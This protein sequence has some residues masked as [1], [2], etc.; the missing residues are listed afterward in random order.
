MQSTGLLSKITRMLRY[1]AI[2]RRQTEKSFLQ[3]WLEAF[4]LAIGTHRLGLAEYY[5]F[6]IFNDQYFPVPGKHKCVGW[7]ASAYIDNTLNHNYWR[8]CANDK[9]LNYAMLAHYGFPIP[10]AVATY[11]PSQRA[12]GAEPVLKSAPE[13][14]AFFR[15]PLP[16]PVFVKPIHGSYGSG[17][18]LLT[19]FDAQ[20][21][22]FADAQGKSLTLPELIK[23]CQMPQFNG[24]L[25]QRCLQPHSAVQ[26]LVGPNTSCVR[27]IVA[28][29]GQGPMVKAAFWKIAR[30]HNITDNFCMGETGNLLAAVNKETGVVQ[31]VVTGL[32]PD[33][34]EVTHHTDT[35]QPLVGFALPDWHRAIEMVLSASHH[36][37]GLRLQHW[38]VAFCQSGPVLMELNTEADLGVP[39]F[40]SRTPFVDDRLGA[41]L[42]P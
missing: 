9:V 13:L 22:C 10:E 25:F 29:T 21:D 27:V 2:A 14:E 26:A 41:M 34:R 28:C 32:W 38:D 15:Q 18:Y 16:F 23:A 17:T 7:R 39:Q 35:Q 20:S 6:E 33:G 5:E 1:A 31:R 24:M 40:L 37:P 30:V 42:E 12:V 8:A 36:F 19:A 11:S 3:Q 4:S